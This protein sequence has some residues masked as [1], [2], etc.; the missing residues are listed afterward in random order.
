MILA[1]S[2]LTGYL[3]FQELAVLGKR[4]PIPADMHVLLADMHVLL[5]DM[6]VL[7]ADMHVL[8]ADDA[9]HVR[10]VVAFTTLP[11]SLMVTNSF[12]K[13]A[14]SSVGSDVRLTRFPAG[15]ASGTDLFDHEILL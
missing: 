2:V 12:L 4:S 13:P 9:R 1:R 6:H 15:N 11:A 10:I 5:A 8:L 3:E 14:S 7:L